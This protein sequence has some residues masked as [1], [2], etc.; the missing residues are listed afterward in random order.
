MAFAISSYKQRV[1]G[2]YKYVSCM[3]SNMSILLPVC[4]TL[5]PVNMNV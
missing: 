4:L 2:K 1:A 3:V 5:Y